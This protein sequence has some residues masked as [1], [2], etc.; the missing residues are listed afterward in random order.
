MSTVFRYSVAFLDSFAQNI[1]IGCSISWCCSLGRLWD[2]HGPDL[3]ALQTRALAA[4]EE[5]NGK[6]T[7]VFHL[8]AIL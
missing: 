8:L 3:E 2:V 4:E 5:E 1:S 6:Q 7:L